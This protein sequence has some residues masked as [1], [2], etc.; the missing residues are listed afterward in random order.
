[1]KTTKGFGIVVLAMALCVWSLGTAMA[2]GGRGQGM[3]RQN[4][5]GA[6]IG[7]GTGICIHPELVTGDLISV[8]GTVSELG[9]IGTGISLVTDP[10]ETVQ[11]YGVGPFRYWE[12]QGMP[13][14]ELGDVITVEGREVTFSEE[15]T[16]FIAF[17]VTMTIVDDE[18]EF[19][20]ITITL[21]DAD[22]GLPL[23]RARGF[24]GGQRMRTG[25]CP[26][27]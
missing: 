4:G 17:S 27:L 23:W 21:R 24:G 6:A 20:T 15:D 1:M 26:N 18:S 10:G 14:P 13:R 8:T 7:D 9:Y 19:T 5:T 25:E 3:G 2:A 11:I 12:D 16:K 22:T